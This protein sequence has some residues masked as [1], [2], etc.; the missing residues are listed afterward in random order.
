[1]FCPKIVAAKLG[2]RPRD[3]ANSEKVEPAYT[4]TPLVPL[5]PENKV[6]A[7]GLSHRN[8][9]IKHLNFLVRLKNE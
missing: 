4:S 9:H 1:M 5:R 2:L 7:N 8:Q 3:V 6:T